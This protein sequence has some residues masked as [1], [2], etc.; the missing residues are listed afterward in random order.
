LEAK[1]KED[2]S[3]VKKKKNKK[4]KKNNQD[5]VSNKEEQPSGLNIAQ[6]I[7]PSTPKRES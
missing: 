4:K 6:P 7:K 1:T 3:Q 5:V 2:F